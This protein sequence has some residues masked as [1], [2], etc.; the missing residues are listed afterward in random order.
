MFKNFNTSLKKSKS[1]KSLKIS[2]PQQLVDNDTMDHNS[3]LLDNNYIPPTPPLPSSSR[4]NSSSSLSSSSAT[5]RSTPASSTVILVTKFDFKAEHTNELSVGVGEALKLI[6]RKGNGWI[7]VKPIGRISPPGLIPASYVRIVRLNKNEQSD[8]KVN[9]K[10]LASSQEVEEPVKA[11]TKCSS[12]DTSISS[13]QEQHFS[14][15]STS[16]SSRPSSPTSIISKSSAILE[17]I[18]PISGLVRNVSC[19]NGRY[20][21]RVDVELNDGKKR[22]LCRY[23]QDFYKLHCSIVD[24]IR[25]NYSSEEQQDACIAKLPALPD[26]I[27]RPDLETLS[28]ILLQRCQSLNVYI[29]KIVQNKH[30]LDYFKILSEWCLPRLGDL[31]SDSKDPISNE[32]IESLLNPM[33]TSVINNKSGSSS[34]H[35]K[36]SLSIQTSVTPPLP[37]PELPPNS[38]LSKNSS[39]I[40]SN[41]PIDSPLNSPK[42]WSSPNTP[43]SATFRDR[44]NSSVN[45]NN[46][47]S[48]SL[49]TRPSFSFEDNW[50]STP[51][52]PLF[53]NRNSREKFVNKRNVSVSS[54]ITT[55]SAD[56]IK[57]KVFHNDDIFAIRFNKSLKLQDLKNSISKRLECDV[58]LI[59]LYYKNSSKNYFSPLSDEFDLHSALDQPKISIKVHLW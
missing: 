40:S 57:I 10:W 35:K 5:P 12:V 19:H 59:K 14:F 32:G 46:H 51:T 15:Q 2:E 22:H 54:N 49:A 8:V 3:Q 18:L 55:S 21:Y 36:P 56:Y 38:M 16:T 27:P 58:N 29:F 26:P 50:M 47:S 43:S 25:S 9:S 28:S 33:P 6:E 7:L 23:Y 13:D 44:S 48:S 11:N 17:T 42:I 53:N 37:V 39:I 4:K 30:K 31:E 20:W 34:S 24:A 52:E 41:S 45:N 1:T